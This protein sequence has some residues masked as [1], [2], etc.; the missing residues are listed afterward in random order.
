MKV[1]WR[2]QGFFGDAKATRAPK[3]LKAR[4]PKNAGTL[5][6]FWLSCTLPAP[7]LN[8]PAISDNSTWKI[9]ADLHKLPVIYLRGTLG[10][11][12]CTFFIAWDEKYLKKMIQIS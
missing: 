5:H 4:L 11:F 9:Q 8:V 2:F 12:T 10:N 1:L 3:F 6:V 7:Y